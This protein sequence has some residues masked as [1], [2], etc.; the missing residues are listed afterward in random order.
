MRIY[1][2]ESERD[3]IANKYKDLASQVATILA[4]FGFILISKGVDTGMA[5]KS[6]MTFKYE[7][8]TIIGINDVNK[9]DIMESLDIG[10]TKV[11]RNTFERTKEIFN[12]SDIVLVLPGGLGTLAELFSFLEE[13]RTKKTNK[14]III[15]NYDKYYDYI[16][17]FLINSHKEGFISNEDLKLI[18]IVNDIDSLKR[19]FNSWER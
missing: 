2:A 13:I 14:R 17:K 19:F 18:S 7:N 4:E 3:G 15:F 12:V 9:A 6:L 11:T 1:L 8:E 16:L 10:D 5:F